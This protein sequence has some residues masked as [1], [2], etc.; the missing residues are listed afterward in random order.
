MFGTMETNNSLA[1]PE[2]SRKLNV[3]EEGF[4]EA[5]P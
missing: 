1:S 5:E 3:N 4:F 2:G